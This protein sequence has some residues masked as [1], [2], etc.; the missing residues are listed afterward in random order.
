MSLKDRV[1][2]IRVE[3]EA[4]RQQALEVMRAIYRDEK[5]WVSADEKLVSVEDLGKDSVSWFV[6]RFEQQPVAVL[7]VL[8]DLISSS[9][10]TMALRWLV[11]ILIWKASF[12]S[13]ELLRLGASPCC[14]NSA[15]TLWS[16][17][18]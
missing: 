4:G 1:S 8:Y 15:N 7:R 18:P 13:T 10:G 16:Q 2:V 17:E 12:V 14:R 5:H 9:T 11:P 3:D 6:V